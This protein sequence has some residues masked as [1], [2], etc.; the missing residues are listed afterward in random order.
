M[1]MLFIQGNFP[2]P[3]HLY[4]KSE[5]ANIVKKSDEHP[6]LSLTTKV[7]STNLFQHALK[8]QHEETHWKIINKLVIP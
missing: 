8:R 5:G 2:L 3:I 1:W 6:V 7:Q 4:G